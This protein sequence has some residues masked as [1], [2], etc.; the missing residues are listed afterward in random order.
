MLTS[1]GMIIHEMYA[2]QLPAGGTP[3]KFSLSL[4]SGPRPTE[5]QLQQM[6][7]TGAT[8][9]ARYLNRGVPAASLNLVSPTTKQIIFLLT[10]DKAVTTLVTPQQFEL[11]MSESSSSMISADSA[12]PTWGYVLPNIQSPDYSYSP[13]MIYFTVGDESSDADMKI[14]GGYI[15]KGREWKPNDLIMSITGGI[16]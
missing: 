9:D 12:P 15:P 4:F 1:A 10:S 6:T 5:R 13:R 11:R 16:F 7:L 14:Q 8:Q 3:G 2:G